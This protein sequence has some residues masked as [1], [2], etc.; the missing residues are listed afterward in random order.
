MYC[1]ADAPAVITEPDEPKAKNVVAVAPVW[2]GTEPAAPPL[3]LV[4]LVAFD[5]VALIVSPACNSSICEP[6]KTNG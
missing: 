6:S 2:Y 5:T 3:I 4:A 1:G